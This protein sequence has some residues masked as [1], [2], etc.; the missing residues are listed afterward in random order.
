[1]L[2]VLFKVKIYFL[3]ITIRSIFVKEFDLINF[4]FDINIANIIKTIQLL[5]NSYKIEVFNK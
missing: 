4:V 3:E 1:M 5:A 2:F